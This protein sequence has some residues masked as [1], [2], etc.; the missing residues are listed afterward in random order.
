MILNNSKIF[1]VT[2]FCTETKR[3]NLAT[4]KQDYS[5]FMGAVPSFG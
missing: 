3:E 1:A 2:F 4:A 5:T